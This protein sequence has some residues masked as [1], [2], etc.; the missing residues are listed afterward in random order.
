MTLD[1]Y[2]TGDII[3]LYT[4]VKKSTQFAFVVK[5]NPSQWHFSLVI[6]TGIVL[7]NDFFPEISHISVLD[8]HTHH[9]TVS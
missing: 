2:S 8:L 6:N 1:Y 5:Y 9:I 3:L 7:Q 4:G